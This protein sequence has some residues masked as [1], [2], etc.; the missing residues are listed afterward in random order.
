[1]AEGQDE[2]DELVHLDYEDALE[3]FA[4]VIGGSTQQAVD[5]L[6]SPSALEGALGR[7]ASYA[8]YGQADL[9]LQG[10]CSPTGSHRLR[11]S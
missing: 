10:R 8:H 2:R 3:I 5:Q 7:P 11:R 9:A 4:A 6:R 1:M